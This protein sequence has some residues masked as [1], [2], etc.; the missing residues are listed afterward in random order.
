MSEK[1][2]LKDLEKSVYKISVQDGIIDIQIGAFLLMFAVAPLLSA[3]LGD[4]WSSVIF[5]PFWAIL[6]L[7][8]RVVKKRFIQPRIGSIEYG[9]F[10][11]KRLVRL[12]LVMLVFNLLAL[13]LGFLSFIQFSDLPGWMVTARFSIIMLVG[14]SLVG[15]MLEFSRMYIYGIMASSAILIGEYLYQ[16]FQISHHGFPVVFGVM[17]VALI[18]TGVTI[19][20]RIIIKNPLPGEEQ[21]E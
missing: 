13:I 10:R 2:S 11:K 1:I 14:F 9:S 17:S 18:I 20:V 15:Y 4:F 6:F 21:P 12:N 8:L 5:L 16:N 3:T 19:M 7:G